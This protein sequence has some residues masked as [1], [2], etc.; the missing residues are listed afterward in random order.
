MNY[1]VGQTEKTSLGLGLHLAFA[2]AGESRHL[3]GFFT[4]N[5]TAGMLEASDT[6]GYD[7]VS[8]FLGAIVNNRCGP[9]E[10]AEITTIVTS[11]L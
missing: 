3:A 8:L 4:E 9:T 6:D 11:Y 7:D 1:F 10:T 2:K 5:E